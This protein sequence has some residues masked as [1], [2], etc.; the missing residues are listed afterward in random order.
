VKSIRPVLQGLDP[1]TGTISLQLWQGNVTKLAAD[2]HGSPGGSAALD[3]GRV[4]SL[5]RTVAENGEHNHH[6]NGDEYND[7]CDL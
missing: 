1:I 2:L 7:D 6:Q 4:A 3:F 5:S